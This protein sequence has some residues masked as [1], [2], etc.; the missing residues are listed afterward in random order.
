[1]GNAVRVEYHEA[2]PDKVEIVLKGDDRY[3]MPLSNR[4]EKQR[5][6][7]GKASRDAAFQAALSAPPG[8]AP[9]VRELAD[10]EQDR[11][12]SPDGEDE[13]DY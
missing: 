1:V 10:D 7:E 6:K 9:E 4:E 5:H 2:H 3:D 13:Q 8:S 12:L 11:R